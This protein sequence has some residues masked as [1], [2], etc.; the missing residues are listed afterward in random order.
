MGDDRVGGMRNSQVGGQGITYFRNLSTEFS[1]L[2]T[3]AIGI[4]IALLVAIVS[5]LVFKQWQQ[6]KQERMTYQAMQAKGFQQS[7]IKKTVFKEVL[8]L[9]IMPMI[10]G[11]ITTLIGLEVFKYLTLDIYHL[12]I[13]PIIICVL[14]YL[15]IAILVACVYQKKVL[16]TAD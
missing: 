13:L 16:K 12:S 4:S 15:I 9:F 3:F 2:K 11:L 10:P 14:V 6:L 5:I 8:S 7:V 1:I